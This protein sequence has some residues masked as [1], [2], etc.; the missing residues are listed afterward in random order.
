MK[1]LKEIEQHKDIVCIDR[2]KESYIEFDG[3][4]IL[5]VNQGFSI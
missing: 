2:E 1:L 3:A 5:S 4:N